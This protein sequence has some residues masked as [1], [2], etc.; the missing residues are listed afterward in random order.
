MTIFQSLNKFFIYIIL[1]LLCN[2]C[3]LRTSIVGI[4][5][6]TLSQ[7]PATDGSPN[8]GTP[9]P[10]APDP[11]PP[12]NLKTP[13][14]WSQATTSPA[15][16]WEYTTTG[17][18]SVLSA[19]EVCLGTVSNTCD[20]VGWGNNTLLT[21]K[22][23]SGLSLSDNTDYYISVRAIDSAGNKSSVV[24]A[25]FKKVPPVAVNNGSTVSGD[26]NVRVKKTNH[27]V[28]CV[29]TETQFSDCVHAGEMR[30]ITYLG[31]SSC[32]G[33]TA[34]DELD[35]FH[36]TC[37]NGAGHITFKAH[38]INKG[39]AL[40]DLITGTSWRSNMIIIKQG[41]V[42][43]AASTYQSWW[44]NTIME[45]P[46][47]PTTTHLSLNSA[48]TIYVINNSKEHGG[49]KI[50]ANNIT[51][52]T[53]G[54]ATLTLNQ[55]NSNLNCN[56]NTEVC[57]IE[58]KLFGPNKFA[59][60]EGKYAGKGN[61][62]A[63]KLMS[64][65]HLRIENVF[66]SNF[67]NG[68]EIDPFGLPYGLIIN[69]YNIAAMN[70]GILCNAF[71][72]TSSLLISN[73]VISNVTGYA[74]NETDSCYNLI[75]ID[76]YIASSGTGIAMS[77]ASGNFVNNRADHVATPLWIFALDQTYERST[78]HHF[79]ATNS[80]GIYLASNVY[81][82][83][84][85]LMILGSSNPV[86]T[87]TTNSNSNFSGKIIFDS[88]TCL[89]QLDTNPGINTSCAYQA[90]GP[91]NATFLQIDPTNWKSSFNGWVHT[92]DAKNASDNL[93]FALKSTIS[94]WFNF[95][96]IYSFWADNSNLLPIPDKNR[97]NNCRI[98]DS[99]IKSTDLVFKNT[100][101]NGIN[102]N[103]AF[104]PGAPC[105]SWLSGNDT[106]T[107]FQPVANT[108]LRNAKELILDEIGDD[109]GLCESNESCIAL[110]NWDTY[111]GS[112]DYYSQGE[113]LFNNGTVTNIK[114]YMY[115]DQN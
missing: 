44:G 48:N 46:D 68:I 45:L 34:A 26:W 53:L 71:S 14:G 32:A 77:S 114:V 85:N 78:I 73:G 113:C 97:C 61:G 54:E 20:I 37:A 15:L 49:F 103:A 30:S 111:Q 72:G 74:I 41:G 83:L 7:I 88:A 16:T 43:K 58:M 36:W 59:W 29:G 22:S 86:V 89:T 80:N 87:S 99:K 11:N 107:D 50:E 27:N 102:Q 110:P 9:P 66:I 12:V 65:S 23:F 38:W 21:Q 4:K 17:N 81:L 95:E 98:W 106:V 33:Y 6:I 60:V 112:G 75:A 101:G 76:N 92:D 108:Y 2:G 1:L 52:T 62:T 40:K 18:A 28:V 115:P 67:N 94:D 82:T 47:N 79:T 104:T 84:S 100:T 25:R 64:I 13:S 96:S 5:D 39:K 51:V 56:S 105:P 31:P 69:N 109:D 19:Y 63:I 10:I 3:F 42:E 57:L 90:G 70:T 35:F 55:V 93:G 8:E 91:T 24:A